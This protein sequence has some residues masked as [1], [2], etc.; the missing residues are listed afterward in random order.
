MFMILTL[1]CRRIVS[2]KGENVGECEQKLHQLKSN[3]QDTLAP[4]HENTRKVAEAL[5]KSAHRFR[6]PPKGPIGREDILRLKDY[7]WSTTVEQ[8]MK[9]SLLNAF[10]VDNERDRV[11]F[12]GIVNRTI[13]RGKFKPECIDFPFSHTQVHDISQ[14]VSRY[15]Y[16]SLKNSGTRMFSRLTRDLAVTIQQCLMWWMSGTLLS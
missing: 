8:L 14:K 1:F 7:R 10:I 9:Y 16:P 11:I 15:S 6:Y 12:N 4:F 13:P 3:R 5:Q 2:E